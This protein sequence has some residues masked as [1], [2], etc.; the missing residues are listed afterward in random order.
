ML[1]TC[2][3]TGQNRGILL[4]ALFQEVHASFREQLKQWNY[5]GADLWELLGYVEVVGGGYESTTNPP[6]NAAG[7]GQIDWESKQIAQNVFHD[8]K[9]EPIRHQLLELKDSP[10]N[11]GHDFAT[12]E[13]HHG[14]RLYELFMR[15][16]L[17]LRIE[18]YVAKTIQ[19]Q[20]S[21]GQGSVPREGKAGESD[22]GVKQAEQPAD[23]ANFAMPGHGDG[24]KGKAG[25]VTTDE[26]NQH[27]DAGKTATDEIVG[28]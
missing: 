25:V 4:T 5:G 17:Q 1:V 12:L 16:G 9:F 18:Q 10:G 11:P 3:P 2:R 19:E 28:M 6:T 27:G 8:E 23:L 26:A 21:K 24:A 13:G 20:Q 14:D 7:N 15:H 22:A